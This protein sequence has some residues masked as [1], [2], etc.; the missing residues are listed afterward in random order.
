[1]LEPLDAERS[2]AYY[3]WPRGVYLRLEAPARLQFRRTA[4]RT[5]EDAARQVV[6]ILDSV[7]ESGPAR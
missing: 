2:R 7:S 3:D 4:G 6:E 1:M 5:A